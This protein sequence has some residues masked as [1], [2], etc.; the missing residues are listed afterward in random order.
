MVKDIDKLARDLQSTNPRKRWSALDK[1][2]KIG[3]TD[4]NSILQYYHL[5]VPAL[6]DPD[7]RFAKRAATALIHICERDIRYLANAIP[8]L[9]NVLNDIAYQ[10]PNYAGSYEVASVAIDIIGT[11][12]DQYLE[13]IRPLVPLLIKCLTFPIYRPES[14]RSGACLLYSSAARALGEIG[15]RKPEYVI[16][17]IPA[18]MKCITDSYK[19]AILRED[20]KSENGLRW[21]AIYA[22]QELLR[23]CPEYIVPALVKYW[24]DPNKDVQKYITDTFSELI[25]TPAKVSR[26][27]PALIQ[28]LSHADKDINRHAVTVVSKVG[29]AQPEY[30][31]PTLIKSLQ[32]PMEYV[33]IKVV[34]ALGRIAETRKDYAENISNTLSMSLRDPSIDVR[35]AAIDAIGKIGE[36]NPEYVKSSLPLLIKFLQ[37]HHS[38]IRLRAVTAFERIG[39][40]NLDY[41]KDA[42]PYMAY[43]LRDPKDEVR[44]RTTETFKLLKIDARTCANAWNTYQQADALI[45]DVKKLGADTK[46]LEDLLTKSKSALDKFEFDE[47]MRYATQVKVD[48]TRVKHEIS[49]APPPGVKR[50][51]K[52]RIEFTK[53]VPAKPRKGW[54]Y[55]DAGLI[56]DFNFDTFV[57]GSFNSFAHAAALAVAKSPAKTYNPLFIYSGVGLGKTHL[58]NAIGNYVFEH[59]KGAKVLYTT[60]ERFT[61]ELIESIRKDKIDEFRAR[62]R[63]ID[64]LLIDDIHFIAGKE[65][66]QEEFFHTFNTLFSAHK[67]I[68]ITSDRPPKEIT[69]LEDRLRSRFECG[70][71]ADIQVPDFETRVAILRKK[72]DALNLEISDEVL[73]FIATHIK[74]NIRELEGGLNKTVAHSTLKGEPISLSIAK[75]AL[76]D[77]LP[78]EALK[79]VVPELREKAPEIA[80]WGVTILVKEEKPER[81]FKF[82]EKL[83]TLGV[84]GLCITR[85]HPDKVVR[86]Y[87]INKKSIIWLSKSPA[88]FSVSPTNLGKL[89]YTIVQFLKKHKDKRPVVL[90]EG[91]EYLIS[92]NNFAKVLRF[93]DDTHETIVLNQAILI[94]PISPSTYSVKEL[95]LLERNTKPFDD[96]YISRATEFFREAG[97]EKA[98]AE[99]IKQVETI[100]NT[101]RTKLQAARAKGVKVDAMEARLVNVENILKTG[102]IP[103]AIKRASELLEAINK[104]E[105]LPSKPKKGLREPSQFIN[106]KVCGEKILRSS[107]FCNK[108][109]SKT[110]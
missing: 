84:S 40:M 92:N 80:E 14:F 109:G 35:L 73:N 76:K 44:W 102:A 33:R 59:D 81:G 1:L 19:Y 93:V 56:E 43:C 83:V 9:G 46:E 5:L 63:N 13:N 7:E 67:Q 16:D 90:L 70:L 21:W 47:G 103:D 48:A 71:V 36:I 88:Q 110:N 82:F 17:A 79:E 65:R 91:L 31:L 85:M 12:S 4:P 11:L 107:V 52:T 61:N 99:R 58:M 2:C 49:I 10:G 104:F 95:T 97:K 78:P 77:I 37:D 6:E 39:R 25:R 64:V 60:S 32:D 15:K 23:G 53:P 62:Y 30:I 87:N 27:V 22:I 18:L 20:A 51:V 94:L 8:A 42:I 41:I 96:A 50:P 100:L 101:I 3:E 72:A 74:D 45:A 66:T 68:I 34:E 75:E 98:E 89:A 105:R 29:S 69:P 24:G 28:C 55:E 108:C 106:C 38:S 26:I 54:T 86:D 57:V